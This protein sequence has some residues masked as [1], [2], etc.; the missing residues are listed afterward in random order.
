MVNKRKNIFVAQKVMQIYA[1][2]NYTC[3]LSLSHLFCATLYI[4]TLL[5]DTLGYES[6]KE[7]DAQNGFGKFDVG[8]NWFF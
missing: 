6:S 5:I 7:F 2:S 4:D 3:S 1:N 8:Q